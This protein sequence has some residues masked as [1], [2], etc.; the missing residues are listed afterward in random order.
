MT[1][2]NPLSYGLSERYFRISKFCESE[3]LHQ[4]DKQKIAITRLILEMQE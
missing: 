1:Y 2:F 4:I 3:I